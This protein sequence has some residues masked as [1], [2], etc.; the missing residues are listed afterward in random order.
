MVGMSWRRLGCDLI[1]Q[2]PRVS[3]DSAEVHSSNPIE[4]GQICN[5]LVAKQNAA[6]LT[7]LRAARATGKGMLF[8]R[9]LVYL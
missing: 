7:R 8:E 4:G 9:S 6:V 2:R 5:Q 1:S 3:L